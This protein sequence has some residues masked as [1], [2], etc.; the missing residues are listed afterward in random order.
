MERSLEDQIYSLFRKSRIITNNTANAL[1][2]L[3]ANQSFVHVF[4]PI[5]EPRD[6]IQD[7]LNGFRSATGGTKEQGER[8][9]SLEGQRGSQ[10]STV[11]GDASDKSVDD[12]AHPGG[13]FKEFLMEHIDLA[14]SEGF[15]DNLGKTGQAFFEVRGWSWF[16]DRKKSLSLSDAKVEDVCARNGG[17][18]RLFRSEIQ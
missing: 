2:A 9:G 3:P 1:I 16:S 6:F 13:G 7:L 14:H 4:P 10:W 8:W 17:A 5:E 18:V 15:N 11:L 12:E